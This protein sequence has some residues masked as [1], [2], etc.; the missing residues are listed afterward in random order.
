[1]ENSDF[2]NEG[3]IL[4]LGVTGA[5][6]SFF[7]NQLKQGSAVEGHTLHS[8]TS[9]CSAV[10]IFLDDEKERTI[11]VVDTPGFDDTEK[12]AGEVLA[13]ITSFLAAQHSV[14]MPL[15]GVLYLHKISDNRMTGSSMK[16]L[17]LLKSL[18]GDD[19]LQNVIFV[20]TMWNKLR[21][22]DKVEALRREQELINDF[23]EPM[24]QK[25]A[26]LAPF[27]GTRGSAFSLVYQLSGKDSVVLNVQRELVDQELSVLETGAGTNLLHQ[28]EE[29]VRTYRQ[30]AMALESQIEE[31]RKKVPQ[32]KDEIRRLKDTKARVDEILAKFQSSIAHMETKPGPGFRQQL[33]ELMKA[34]GAEALGGAVAILSAMLNLTVFVVHLTTGF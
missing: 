33:R 24:V 28:L 22:E 32:N 11:T 4:L 7:L 5:G 20:T 16:Y 3:I 12:P 26:F 15:R 19:A 30:E 18:V 13:E 10:R 1:M 31:E 23:W 9:E 34:R 27:D 17:R 25:G 2:S 21:D 6:K 8:E 29:D 14:G